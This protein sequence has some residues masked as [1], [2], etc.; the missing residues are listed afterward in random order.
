MTLQK[1]SILLAKICLHQKFSRATQLLE[2]EKHKI[3]LLILMMTCISSPSCYE[4]TFQPKLILFVFIIQFQVTFTDSLQLSCS[5]NFRFPKSEIALLFI[6]FWFNS[7][8]IRGREE[9]NLVS[10]HGQSVG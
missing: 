2:I 7:E 8:L 10:F 9:R 5:G 4:K 1:R 6:L 3:Y